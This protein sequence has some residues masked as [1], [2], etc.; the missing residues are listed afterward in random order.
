[1]RLGESS[2]RCSHRQADDAPI[3]AVDAEA[4][5]W[6][7]A[8]A[9]GHLA[10]GDERRFQ[11]WMEASAANRQ[12]FAELAATWHWSK[13]PG[14]VAVLTA[15]RL[16]ED[17]TGLPPPGLAS[18]GHLQNGRHAR[19]GLRR[20]LGMA[21]AAGLAALALLAGLPEQS[22]E[23]TVIATA[24]S[25]L[26]DLDLPDGSRISLSGD[27]RLAYR[28]DEHQ[29][30]LELLQGEAYFDIARDGRPLQ[31]R[32]H[33]GTVRVLGTA[34]NIDL[35]A[36]EVAEV[37]VYEGSV[38]VDSGTQKI[39]LGVGEMAHIEANGTPRKSALNEAGPDWR[40]GW[41]V[42][43]DESL[44][45]VLQEAARFSK[46]PLELGD[47]ALEHIRLSG[48]IRVA[49]PERVLAMLERAYSLR[50]QRQAER[51]VLLPAR[52]EG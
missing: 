46:L 29:R 39:E 7:M 13:D 41:F 1:M 50:V 5:A 11:Q 3:A 17:P 14:T 19:F 15:P 22:P 44:A 52:E 45:R 40:K 2:Q 35:L 47:P 10:A 51:I 23:P 28:L 26:V 25:E 30:D 48:R 31:V 20:A 4:A 24:P 9:D 49:E 34:F 6:V 33:A 38:Q 27:T 18:A 32:T 16:R 43:R 12:R 42:A 36:A 21:V 8:L 37:T